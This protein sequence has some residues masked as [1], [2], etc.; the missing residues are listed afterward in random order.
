MLKRFATILFF[1]FIPVGVFVL[2]SFAAESNKAMQCRSFHVKIT[3]KDGHNFV[4][5][6]LVVKQVYSM[7]DSLPGQELRELC[8]KTIEN[9]INEMYYVEASQVYR[10]IDGA[11]VARIKQRQPLAR[12]I[13]T[14]NESYYLDRNGRMMKATTRY[15]ARVVV[16]SGHIPAR[17]SPVIDLTSLIPPDELSRSELLLRDLY[18]LIN[19]IDQDVF[20]KAWIDQV[21]VTRSGGFEL[22]PK[23]GSHVIELG[24]ASDLDDKFKKLMVFYKTGLTRVGWNNYKKINLKYKNQVVCSK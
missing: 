21:F 11:V 5:S 4:D 10:T 20:L 7:F 18:T 19:Y 12:I 8:L 3:Q 2:L 9:L 24:D 1:V 17:Y 13:N 14:Y 23:N 6:S 16:V 15:S 22:I